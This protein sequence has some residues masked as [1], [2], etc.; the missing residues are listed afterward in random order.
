MFNNSAMANCY[1]WGTIQGEESVGGL[2]GSINRSID[3]VLEGSVRTVIL[4]RMSL[5]LYDMPERRLA[6]MNQPQT[7]RMTP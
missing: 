7:L 2:C 5:L 4:S 6:T 1:A 3:P